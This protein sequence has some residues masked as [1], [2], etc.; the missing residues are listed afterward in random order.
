M[1]IGELLN[2]E[3][4]STVNKEGFFYKAL[5]SNSNKTGAIENS[6]QVW[7][8]FAKY[9]INTPFIYEQNGEMLTNTVKYFSFLERFFNESDESLKNR[10]RAI[11]YRNGD[12][13]WGSTWNVINVFK[14]YFSNSNVFLLENTNDVE[15]NIIKNNVFS[16]NTDNWILTG[17]ALLDVNARFVKHFGI[18]LKNISELSQNV[19][20]TNNQV[21]F[22]H[23]FHN[24][25]INVKIK[26]KTINKYWNNL[27]K[28]WQNEEYSILFDSNEWKN[29]QIFF[30][31]L[32]FEN[33][34]QSNIEISF[35]TNDTQTCYID[36]ILLY[37][38]NPYCSFT[39]LIHTEGDFAKD[40]L[41]LAEGTLDNPN[42]NTPPEVLIKKENWGYYNDAYI[43]GP[44]SGYAK[45]VYLDLLNYVRSCGVKAFIEFV[46]KD[47]AEE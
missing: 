9:Y 32:E 44:Q 36:Y 37:K 38:K 42:T 25:T 39:I 27:N 20:I 19:N 10:F 1:R 40:R 14:E 21:Y 34:N 26:N 29:E 23:F 2:L 5:V 24:G 46:T 7:Q 3:M 47:I 45:E 6:M 31:L 28:T 4:P 35:F 43:T 11:F 16:D 22:L 13:S 15:E 17:N 33:D 41:A 8:D 12:V 18:S 30:S